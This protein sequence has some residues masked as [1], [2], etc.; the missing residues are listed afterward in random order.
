MKSE[1]LETLEGM[2]ATDLRKGAD[3]CI[4]ISV[5]VLLGRNDGILTAV[6]LQM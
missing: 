5:V 6:L 4:K 3:I 2:I 1:L